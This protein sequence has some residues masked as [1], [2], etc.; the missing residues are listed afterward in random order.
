MKGIRIF[1]RFEFDVPKMNREG[2]STLFS[3][4]DEWTFDPTAF[5]WINDNTHAALS[6]YIPPA[7]LI[8]VLGNKVNTRCE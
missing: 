1:E 3:E 6:G 8:N 7:N 5:D 2:K 4:Y